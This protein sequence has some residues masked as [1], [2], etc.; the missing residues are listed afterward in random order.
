MLILRLLIKDEKFIRLFL[1]T[2]L[3]SISFQVSSSRKFS[4]LSPVPQRPAAIEFKLQDLTGDW[5]TISQYKNKTVIVTFWATW[6]IPCRIEMP[7]MQRAW[8]KFDKDSVMMLGINVGEDAEAISGFLEEVPVKFPILMD[9]NSL[10]MRQWYVIGL[11]TTYVVNPDGKVVYKAIGGREWDD[12]Y[13]IS[14]I[15]ALNQ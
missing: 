14:A 5:H 1:I 10:T 4:G 12:E 9:K 11:P 6:C 8:E 7:S 15:R 13:F 2:L 3:L